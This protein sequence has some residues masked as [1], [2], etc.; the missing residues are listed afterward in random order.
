MK[1]VHSLCFSI[2]ILNG[3]SQLD[4]PDHT[5]TAS[6]NDINITEQRPIDASDYASHLIYPRETEYF[7]A[8]DDLVIYEDPFYGAAVSYVD[9]RDYPDI[10]T[11]F[12]Y[13]IPATSWRNEALILNSELDAFITELDNTV[14]IGAYQSRGPEQRSSYTVTKNGQ[15]FTGMKVHFQ[16]TNKF[17][18]EYNADA[19]IFI[20]KDKFIKIRTSSPK[21]FTPEWNGDLI[22]NELLPEFIVPD[23]SDYMRNLRDEQRRQPKI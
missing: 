8:V 11:V 3:C 1:V 13:P 10:I 4:R 20:Q 15:T 21:E 2:L 18:T 12:I 16:F 23:E 6:S 19:Y 17:G 5:A 14:K 7:V 9:K 22:A